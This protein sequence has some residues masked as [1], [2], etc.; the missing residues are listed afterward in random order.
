MKKQISLTDTW[1]TLILRSLGFDWI[2]PAHEFER[3][4]GMTGIAA[5]YVLPNRQ[6]SLSLA[7]DLMEDNWRNN[8][9]ELG[10]DLEN[11][12]HNIVPYFIVGARKAYAGNLREGKDVEKYAR[13]I[14]EKII[15]LNQS[16]RSLGRVNTNKIDD[17]REVNEGFEHDVELFKAGEDA[18]KAF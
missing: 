8:L 2:Y 9:L 17:K 10:P 15:K 11:G 7:F 4:T 6:T 12:L 1:R 5:D 14:A 3:L 18:A 16:L 13:S